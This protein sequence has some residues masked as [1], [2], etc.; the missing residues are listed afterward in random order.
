M[1]VAAPRRARRTGRAG[2]V[3][4]RARS[5][6]FARGHRCHADLCFSSSAGCRHDVPF[7]TRRCFIY[8]DYA[9]RGRCAGHGLM[10]ASENFAVVKQ[11]DCRDDAE[12][13][14]RGNV[15]GSQKRVSTT[16]RAAGVSALPIGR[17]RRHDYR[18]Q[19]VGELPE[20]ASSPSPRSSRI[21]VDDS[22]RAPSSGRAFTRVRGAIW[23]TPA[24]SPAEE[25][26]V[27]CPSLCRA[28][29]GKSRR[30]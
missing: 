16:T 25:L 5:R 12:D 1:V 8:I 22:R 11:A 28:I 6:Q 9:P 30:A 20:L 13:A 18:P 10:G 15:A 23:R 3:A 24:W 27:H 21:C 7:M 29:F 14:P 4:P 2:D 19:E 17:C 26:E